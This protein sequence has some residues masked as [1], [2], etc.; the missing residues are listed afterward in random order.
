MIKPQ[1]CTKDELTYFIEKSLLYTQTDFDIQI[2]RYR[3]DKYDKMAQDECEKAD[4]YRKQLI[5][6]LKKYN[7][8]KCIDIPEKDMKKMEELLQKIDVHGNKSEKFLRIWAGILGDLSP[9]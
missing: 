8:F 7:G 3:S 5:V 4:T 9:R 1:D 2:R 6:I